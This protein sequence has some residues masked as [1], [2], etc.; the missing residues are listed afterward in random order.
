M[1][2]S[3][4]FF[5]LVSL[6]AFSALL[7]LILWGGVTYWTWSGLF[8]LR[9]CLL[10]SSWGT[11]VG[12][13]RFEHRCMC[14]MLMH[15]TGMFCQELAGSEF[16]LKLIVGFPCSWN[17]RNMIKRNVIWL[18]FVCVFNLGSVPFESEIHF[19]KWAGFG[20]KIL[21]PYLHTCGHVTHKQPQTRV[22]AE[23]VQ[24]LS[25]SVADLCAANSA[26]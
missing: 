16:K 12:S 20:V 25:R 24:L 14:Q 2:C 11:V 17:F 19:W 5:S 18:G 21:H 10:C 9:K 3:H 13:W 26:T 7:F 1:C 6:S 15:F 8:Y 22:C 4:L 23:P